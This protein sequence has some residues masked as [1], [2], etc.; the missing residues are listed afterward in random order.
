MSRSRRFGGI[1]HRSRDA[2]VVLAFHIHAMWSASAIGVPRCPLSYLFTKHRQPKNQRRLSVLEL[3]SGCGIVGICFAKLLYRSDVLLTDLPEAMEILALNIATAEKSLASET[4]L[5]RLPL[6]WECPLPLAVRDRRYD[7]VLVSDCTYNSDSLPALVRTLS[8]IILQSPET[9]IIVS[10]KVRHS[11][12]AVFFELM[13]D[14]G[15]VSIGH[16]IIALPDDV[17]EQ[18]GQELENVEIYTF[19]NRDNIPSFAKKV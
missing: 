10:M 7:L 1:S 9:L 11:S 17:R 16:D 14:A 3:G 12:E 2:G 13:L 18:Q 15:T 8:A 5:N 4:T 6:D 19:C